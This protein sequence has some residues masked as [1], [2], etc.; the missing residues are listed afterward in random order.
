MIRGSVIPPFKKGIS[1]T[2]DEGMN[3]HSDLV[4]ILVQEY[5]F[6]RDIKQTGL[7]R[8]VRFL[9]LLLDHITSVF[10]IIAGFSVLLIAMVTTYSVVRRYVFGSPDNN[11]ILLICILML[12]SFVFSIAHVQRLGKHIA[13]DYLSQL[14]PDKIRKFVIEVVGPLLGLVLCVPLVWK[15]WGNA[16]FALRTGQRTISITPISTFPM[17]ITIP[18]FTGLLCLVLVAQIL[19]YF[20]SLRGK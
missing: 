14:L 3:P 12:A 2:K 16:W 15:T 10:L 18:I 19:R 11:A 13:V 17:Q 4:D 9:G 5:I 7:G 6:M 1:E 8:M 20:I